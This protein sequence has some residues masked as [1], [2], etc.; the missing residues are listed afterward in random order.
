[1]S[2]TITGPAG[3]IPYSPDWLNALS[4]AERQSLSVRNFSRALHDDGGAHVAWLL[5]SVQEKD[6]PTPLVYRKR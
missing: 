4:E 3:L 2:S 1:M 5:W 6:R